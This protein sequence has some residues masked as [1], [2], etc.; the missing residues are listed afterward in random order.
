MGRRQKFFARCK[1]WASRLFGS[2]NGANGMSDMA[3]K[4]ARAAVERSGS[5]RDTAYFDGPTKCR[6]QSHSAHDAEPYYSESINTAHDLLTVRDRAVGIP[7]SVPQ[8]LITDHFPVPPPRSLNS[9][10]STP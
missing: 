5:C 4:A 2:V 10:H 9:Q 3:G 6:W 7:G 1:R 8:S